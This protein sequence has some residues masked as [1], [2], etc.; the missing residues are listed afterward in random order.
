M[1]VLALDLSLVSTGVATEHGTS[2]IKSKLKGVERL[3]EIR[4]ALR[5][6]LATNRPDV[7]FVE[8][9]AMGAKGRVFDIGE[10]GGVVKVLLADLSIPCEVVPPAS[11]KKWATGKGNANK[12][13]MLETAI[14]K[15]GFEGHGNDEADAWLL[16]KYG[17]WHEGG[18]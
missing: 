7:V 4:E 12:D 10:L 9:Y 2:R 5:E 3:I 16:Y 6:I 1:R 11:L 14:R 17:V 13:T 18:Q 15:F 8:G